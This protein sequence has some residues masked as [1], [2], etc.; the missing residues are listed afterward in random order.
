MDCVCC[1]S[2]LTKAELRRCKVVASLQLVSEEAV[3]QMLECSDNYGCHAN[4]SIRARLALFSGAPLY[5]AMT[6]ASR[7][8]WGVTEWVQEKV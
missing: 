6:F 2:A 5:N 7:Q 4:R 1:R 8:A 3:D